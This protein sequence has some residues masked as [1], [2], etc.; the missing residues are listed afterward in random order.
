MAARGMVTAPHHLAAQSGL[1][2]LRDGGNA[3]EAAIAAVATISV[4]Y[5]HMCGLGGDAFWLIHEPGRPPVSI[6]GSG[7]AA[8]AADPAGYADHGFREAMPK[9]G[10][11]AACT[12]AGAVSSWQAALELSQ[13]WEGAL[14]LSRL[15]ADAIH[16]ARSGH[17]VTG[18][19]VEAATRLLDQLKDQ[20]GF[21][22]HFL[23]D[24]LP[25]QPGARATLPRLADTFERLAKFGLDDFYRGGLGYHIGAE[26]QRLGSPLAAEDM[27]RHR[28]IRRRPL[29]IALDS[30]TVFNTPPPTQGLASLMILGLFQRLGVTEAEGFAHIHGLV[31]ATK[32]AFLVRN[33][34]VTDP[35]HMTIHATT[36]L[37]DGLLDRL[38]AGISPA[39]AAP[40]PQP[41]GP[42]DTIWIGVTDDAGRVVSLIQSLS[43]AFGSG[44]ML[45]DTG[46]LWHN[47]GASFQLADGRQNRLAPRRKPFHTLSPG[48]ALL[49]DGRV[50]AYGTMGGEGQ[51]QTLAALYT[52]HVQ[53]GQPL[54]QAVTA[55]RWALGRGWSG[56]DGDLKLESRFDPAVVEAL[57]AAGH[58]VTLLGPYDT[59]MGHAGALVR[60]T[61]GLI[62]GAADPR[63]DG[64]VAGY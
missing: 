52:R 44:V 22:E 43:T 28:S 42:G 36:Y 32:Q 7:V 46:I 25:P 33:I 11:L 39:E 45:R 60:H 51:P 27:A 63:G 35:A 18:P 8:A 17:A 61:D 47:R 58:A 62:E 49:K 41:G 37:T 19:Q 38:A 40:W 31:E 12:V 50:M 29:S 2:V 14:P 5:P 26:L 55:P 56:P 48:L 64:V 1:A 3:I 34:H 59:L 16:Y 24:G 4:V 57:R 23:K 15:F 10:P 13:R 20:P 9:H 30:G 53:F 21:A 54:Q 6:D